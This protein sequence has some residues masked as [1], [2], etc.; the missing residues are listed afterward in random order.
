MVRRSRLFAAPL[1]AV[2]LLCATPAASQTATPEATAAAR[3]RLTTMRM[4]DQLRAILPLLMKQLGPVIS[5]GRPE[6]ERDLAALT[7]L[8]LELVDKRSAELIDATAVVYVR[9]F[10]PEEMR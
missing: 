5:Q 4:G 3:E 7:P 1:L 6:V 9:H 8:M 2:T 10:T